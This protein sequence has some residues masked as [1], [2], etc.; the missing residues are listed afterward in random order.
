MS[1]SRHEFESLTERH[2]LALI[3]ECGVEVAERKDES[4]KFILYNV[5]GLYVE[6]IR[7]AGNDAWLDFCVIEDT[8]LLI[9]FT[10]NVE[11]PC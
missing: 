6:E 10:L 2:Q 5:D 7:T 9:P 11:I 1:L 8:D 4:F 3:L